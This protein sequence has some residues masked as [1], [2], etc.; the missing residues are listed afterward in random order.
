MS[1]D[2]PTSL[3][4]QP[5]LLFQ[6]S[7]IA[8]EAVDWKTALDEITHLVRPFFIFDHVVV[9]LPDQTGKTLDVL[10]ARATGRGRKSEEDISWGETVATQVFNTQKVTLQEPELPHIADRLQAPFMLGVP[11]PTGQRRSGALVFIRFGGPSY[12]RDD[13]Q[14]ARFITEQ[15]AILVER[16]AIQKEYEMLEAQH[17]QI[18]L[19]E[20]FISTITHELRSPLGFIK[21]YTTT[22]LRSDTTWDETT[23]SEFLQIIDRETDHLQ[24]LIENLLDSARLQSGQMPMFFQAVRLDALINSLIGREKTHHPDRKIQL[25]YNGEATPIQGDPQRLTQVFENLI[26]NAIKYAPESDILITIKQEPSNAKII[27]E[28]H[29]PGISE[30]FLPFLF[31]RFFRVPDPTRQMRGSGLGLYICKQIVQAHQG[32]IEVQSSL[33]NGTRFI[34]NLPAI[35]G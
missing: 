17:Q 32:S 12:R 13:V 5:D 1:A 33:G 3:S 35:T 6:V 26:S 10:Y 16:A 7:K 9:Y 30:E 34:I 23:Q 28:D 8:S 22:L 29:G 14:L 20:D 2:L 18:R 27:L 15:I 24:G 4:V 25:A 11:I 19:Q 31:D 21:G